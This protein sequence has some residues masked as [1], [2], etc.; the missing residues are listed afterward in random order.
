MAAL[1]DLMIRGQAT[2]QENELYARLAVPI[3][4]VAQRERDALKNQQSRYIDFPRLRRRR[5]DHAGAW[6]QALGHGK[7]NQLSIA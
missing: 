4:E 2:S 1:G 5:G 7:S 6:G 3:L